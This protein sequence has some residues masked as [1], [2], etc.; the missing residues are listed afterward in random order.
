MRLAGCGYKCDCGI[1]V[2]IHR[3]DHIEKTPLVK[4][5]LFEPHVRLA[6]LQ[7]RFNMQNLEVGRHSAAIRL[8]MSVAGVLTMI[9]RFWICP[10]LRLLSSTARRKGCC[11]ETKWII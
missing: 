1:P 2:N 6:P 5:T 7:E 11:T 3:E 10:L 9:I 4:P 8:H